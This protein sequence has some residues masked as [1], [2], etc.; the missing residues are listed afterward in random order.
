MSNLATI[1]QGV[2]DKTRRQDLLDG[3][4]VDAYINR[5]VRY[6]DMRVEHPKQFRR[7][8]TATA[9][10]DFKVSIPRLISVKRL[11]IK[12]SLGTSDVTEFYIEPEQFRYNYGAL[13]D[14]WETGE[15]RYWTLN[16]NILSPTQD[17][18]TAAT[19]A[20]AGVIDEDDLDF[21]EDW[22]SSSL[23]FNP[24][25]DG[26]YTIDLLGRFYS[27][28]LKLGE[29]VNF[30]TKVHPNLLELTTAYFLEQNMRNSAGQDVWLRAMTEEIHQIE[31]NLAERELAGRESVIDG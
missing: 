8:L 9:V 2:V 24:K 21:D 20:A 17:A 23:M 22:D 16:A 11:W 10:G 29:D 26:V 4:A 1:R 7:H 31:V 15:P 27:K 6:L 5:A 13:I 14:A 3:D 18:E 28:D 25:A 19:L 30:W 12:D